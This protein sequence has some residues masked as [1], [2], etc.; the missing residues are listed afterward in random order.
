MPGHEAFRFRSFQLFCVSFRFG[1][2]VSVWSFI[3]FRFSSVLVFCFVLMVFFGFVSDRFQSFQFFCF[4][5]I[6]SVFLFRF[7]PKPVLTRTRSDPNQNN[8]FL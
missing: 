6:L 7:D 8:P 5:S 4:V 3:R 2:L 1:F